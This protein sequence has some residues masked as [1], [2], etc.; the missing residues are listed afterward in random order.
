[1]MGAD[2]RP[3]QYKYLLICA[4]KATKFQAQLSRL[5]YAGDLFSYFLVD[6]NTTWIT[7]IEM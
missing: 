2:K 3:K 4:G 7:P 1:M 6:P 5:S